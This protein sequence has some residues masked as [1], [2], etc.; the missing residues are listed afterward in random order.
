M[1]WLSLAAACAALYLAGLNYFKP[2]PENLGAKGW[3]WAE[4]RC[5][6]HG[7]IKGFKIVGMRWVTVVCEEGRGAMAE[8]RGKN[9]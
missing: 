2:V 6:D 3:E 1:N 8:M 4:S 7:G 9:L 5:A